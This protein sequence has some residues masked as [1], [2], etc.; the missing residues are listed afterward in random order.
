M[1][2]QNPTYSDYL[3]NPSNPLFLYANESPSQALVSQPL[4]GRNYH[5]WARA[6]KLALLSKNKLKLVDGSI[7][8]LSPTDSYYGAWERCNNIDDSIL[9]SILW[10]DQAS[11][12]WVSDLQEEIFR[13]QQ[14][15][16]T[17]SQYFTQLKGL[18]DEF[19]N[20]RRVLHCK[21][22]IPC[23][24][25]AIQA[26]KKYRDQ[27]YVIRFLKGLNEQFSHVRSQIMLLDPL[28]P[29]NKVF[30]LI[31][32]QER[33]MTTTE[34]TELSSDAKTFAVNTDQ[35]IGLGRGLVVNPNQY[36]GYGR[37]RR[38]RGRGRTTIG[39]GQNSFNKLY[40]Y[41]GKTNHTV[42][43]CYFKHG[44]PQGYK[45]RQSNA[46]MANSNEDCAM[47]KRPLNQVGKYYPRQKK[48]PFVSSTTKSIQ[49]FDLL[50]VDIGG[51]CSTTSIS[52]YKYVLTIIDD[53][54]RFTWVKL[55]KH[56]GETRDHLKNFVNYIETQFHAKLKVIRSDN[57]PEFFMTKFYLAKGISH[58]TTCVETPQQNDVAERKHQHI[59][60]V[61]QPL[62]FQTNLPTSLWSY[63]VIHSVHLINRLLTPLLQ[64]Q[65]PYTVFHK[66]QPDLS[67]L[68]VFG[69]LAYSNTLEHGRTKLSP[70]ARKA[71]FIGYKEGTK[72]YLL[73]DIQSRQIFVSRNVV[74]C[75]N[76]FPF[77]SGNESDITSPALP[78]PIC[79]NI[80]PLDIDD[81]TIFSHQESVNN[82]NS[83]TATTPHPTVSQPSRHSMRQRQRPYYLRDY[84]CYLSTA[85]HTNLS[86][87]N[88]SSSLNRRIA[89]TIALGKFTKDENDLF[90]IMD[91]WL[92][93]D[94]FIFVGWSGLLLFPCA[95]FAL[96][97]WFTGWV[98]L[99]EK[100]HIR[101]KYDDTSRGINMQA[102]GSLKVQQQ[103]QA[104]NGAFTYE[105]L[106][107]T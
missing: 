78:K 20:Y 29:I 37:G 88:H 84:H 17:V 74:F 81:L 22:S 33:Q 15:T 47:E 41:C 23:T 40:T 83:V 76:S 43:T 79:D 100:P 46:N 32:Q 80:A 64:N 102:N 21:C 95:Y 106:L 67:H 14:G 98:A 26:Y 49:T 55:M 99:K 27:D 60:N 30:S 3:T 90:D 69:C 42:E 48:L 51:P 9:Q 63:A 56:K 34:M 28:P 39:R 10:I 104:T 93:R 75:E 45:S 65:C 82:S 96:G 68:R 103:S 18:W 2:N 36:F 44:F 16:L 57:G 89:M 11:E 107:N 12:V 70:K 5:S 4:N 13:L 91:D 87:G 101:F 73:Y 6:M 92:R 72:G 50:H 38:N 86:Y 8:S 66:Q 71:I 54:S 25:E 53:F 58:Q 7:P 62:M 85:S 35:Y 61:V 31:V 59:M 1:A 97:G 77:K 19:E 52:G 105:P 94:R 24:C